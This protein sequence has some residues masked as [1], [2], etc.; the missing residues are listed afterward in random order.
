MCVNTHWL[1]N[2]NRYLM[3]TSVG[4]GVVVKILRMERARS[5]KLSVPVE[6]INKENQTSRVLKQAETL[7]Y[8]HEK[9]AV[10]QTP[11]ET[12]VFSTLS[13]PECLCHRFSHTPFLSFLHPASYTY[14]HTHMIAG[15]QALTD[16]GDQIVELLL[17]EKRVVQ[18]AEVHFQH[19]CY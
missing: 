18:V 17:G 16:A 5:Y 2:A 19:A 12:R 3:T 4:R 13:F 10:V 11:Q 15:K 7:L 1:R 9:T 14:M 6:F 8:S